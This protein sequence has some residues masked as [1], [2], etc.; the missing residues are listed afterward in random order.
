MSSGKVCV[1][2][3]RWGRVDRG[4]SQESFEVGIEDVEE[5]EP[6]VSVEQD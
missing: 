1:I 3:G 2:R 4:K 6:Q 5:C